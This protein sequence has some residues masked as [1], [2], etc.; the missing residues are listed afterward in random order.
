MPPAWYL[1]ALGASSFYDVSVLD[2]G[3]V[4]GLARAKLIGLNIQVYLRQKVGIESPAE[5]LVSPA[6][7]T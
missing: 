3:R 4:S 1:S 6:G 7:E 5:E 2:A